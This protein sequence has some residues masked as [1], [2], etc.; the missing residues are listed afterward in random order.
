MLWIFFDHWDEF[1]DVNL[2]AYGS[3]V[4]GDYG[5]SLSMTL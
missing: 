4:V 1:G 5:A 3:V 2:Q